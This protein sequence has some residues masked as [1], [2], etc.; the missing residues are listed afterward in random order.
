MFR[1][2]HH[3]AL[4][5]HVGKPPAAEVAEHAQR[6]RDDAQEGIDSV[7]TS[8]ASSRVEAVRDAAARGQRRQR[9]NA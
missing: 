3:R 6:L 1:G 7:R 4:F 8:L 9:L 2:K 5:G